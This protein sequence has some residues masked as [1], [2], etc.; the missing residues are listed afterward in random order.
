MQGTRSLFAQPESSYLKRERERDRQ[1]L[2]E[3]P[4]VTRNKNINE[5]LKNYHPF[6]IMWW[7]NL[8]LN[9]TFPSLVDTN[10]LSFLLLALK[11]QR[12]GIT[13]TSKAGQIK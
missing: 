7:A 4:R 11:R 12:L 2:I 1:A 13:H 10:M 3:R 9:K 6:N 5:V 8:M